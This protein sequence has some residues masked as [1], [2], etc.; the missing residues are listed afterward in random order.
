[1]KETCHMLVCMYSSLV[2]PRLRKSKLKFEASFWISSPMATPNSQF[3]AG[4]GSRNPTAVP[5]KVIS[6]YTIPMLYLIS[7]W[8]FFDLTLFLFFF[9]GSSRARC[10]YYWAWKISY[11]MQSYQ[12]TFYFLFDYFFFVFCYLLYIHVFCFVF[13]LFFN[14]K[15]NCWVI[16]Y[17]LLL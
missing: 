7:Q 5:K 15:R 3:P 14:D 13:L 11:G 8:G 1:M 2:G 9:T 17:Q 12:V 4:S 6:S 10:F 16:T